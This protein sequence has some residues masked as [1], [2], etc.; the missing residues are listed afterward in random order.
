MDVK[1]IHELR[2]MAVELTGIPKSIKR[3]DRVAKELNYDGALNDVIY[4]VAK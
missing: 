4:Q 3:T 2:Q 1:D